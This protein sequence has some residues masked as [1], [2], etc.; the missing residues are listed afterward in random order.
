MKLSAVLLMSVAL[1][2]PAV[3]SGPPV[4]ATDRPAPSSPA[5]V[6]DW[7]RAE[8]GLTVDPL[9]A[10]EFASPKRLGSLRFRGVASDHLGDGRDVVA[11]YDDEARTIYLPH[12]WTGATPAEISVLVHEMVHHAQNLS[13][14]KFDCPQARERQAYEAQGR[15]L[16]DSGSDLAV[17]FGID[18]F[19]L[20]VLTN[21]G[22]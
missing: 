5:A 11:I 10:I 19:S 17:S 22:L 7:L 8:F 21:C 2:A 4:L 20:L 16:A 13:R 1:L 9:P 18:G 12:D 6:A 3:W 14:A 15:W